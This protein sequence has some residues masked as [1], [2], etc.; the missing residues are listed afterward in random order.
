[1]YVDRNLKQKALDKLGRL[2]QTKSV[3]SYSAE[4]QHTVAPLN[5]DDNSKQSL[6]YKGLS[7]NIKKSLI[8]FSQAKMFDEL[9]EQCISVDQRQYA[10]RQEEKQSPGNSNNFKKPSQ[11]TNLNSGSTLK[12]KQPGGPCGPLS[13]DEKNRRR[14]NNLCFR[15]GSPKHRIGDCPLDKGHVPNNPA[16]ASNVQIAPEHLS[17]VFPPEN[18]LSQGTSRPVS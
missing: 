7:A 17:P 2:E 3:A 5:L 14:E 1:M 11:P 12:Q 18:W 16:K 4:F 13:Q 6:F 8:Y 15:C 10:L 9:L